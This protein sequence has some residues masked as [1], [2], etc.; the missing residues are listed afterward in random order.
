MKNFSK[1]FKKITALLLTVVTVIAFTACS[2]D[3]GGGNNYEEQIDAKKTNIYVANFDGGLGKVWLQNAIKRFESQNAEVS[4]E[5]DKKG[6]HVIIDDSLD[7]E[8]VKGTSLINII[9][10]NRAH[11]F[12]TEQVYYK[13]FVRDGLIADIT[14]VVKKTNTDG[15]TIESK[16][17]REQRDYLNYGGKY[18]M[19]PFYAG[20]TGIMYDIDL[21]VA[22]NLYFGA[23]EDSIDEE[24][25]IV[26]KRATKANGPDGEPNTPDDGLPATYDEFFKLCTRMIEKDIIPFIWSGEYMDPYTKETLVALQADYEGLDQ[27]MLNY[28]LNGRATD[29]VTDIVGNGFDAQ[30]TTEEVDITTDNG[31]RILQQAGKYYALAFFEKMLTM[32]V[33]GKKLY[34]PKSVNTSYS[35]T[36][37]QDEFL[38]SRPEGN[39]IAMLLDGVWWENEASDS[40]TFADAAEIYGN[41]YSKEQRNLGVMYLPKANNDKFGANTVVDSKFSAAFINAAIKNAGEKKAAE[42]FLAFCYTDDS[43]V[44]FTQTTNVCMSLEYELTGSDL[45]KLSP[46]GRNAYIYRKNANKVFAYSGSDFFGIHAPKLKTEDLFGTKTSKGSFNVPVT[47]FKNNTISAAEYFLGIASYY[48]K[49]YWNTNYEYNA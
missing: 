38:L 29:I 2:G 25:F 42:D 47:T 32:T 1:K 30:L 48:S 31:Y 4:Y 28:T 46:F 21:F 45:E 14:D 15:K 18:Y 36:D 17:T 13:E 10:D 7:K 11:L 8:Q 43:L 34:S 22:E 5:T 37:A 41:Q 23:D 40:N 9:A 20:F 35:H 6:V 24:G 16:L 44:K 26:N 3:N 49:D 12:F 39:P 27:M 19:L 33:S